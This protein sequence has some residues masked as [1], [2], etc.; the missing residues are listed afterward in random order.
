MVEKYSR[1]AVDIE[2]IAVSLMCARAS[3]KS[4]EVCAIDGVF[5]IEKQA[6]G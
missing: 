4:V 1:R 2:S 6:P 3:A 5:A